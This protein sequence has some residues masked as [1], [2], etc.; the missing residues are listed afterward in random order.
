MRTFKLVR[1]VDDSGVSGVGVVAEGVEF[2]N[3]RVVLG[4]T[5][6]VHSVGVYDDVES[7]EA[8]HGHGGKTRIVWDHRCP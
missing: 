1:D 8:I 2:E 6:V 4:W 7:V 5:T 3:G